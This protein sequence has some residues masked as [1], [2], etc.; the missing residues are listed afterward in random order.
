MS[1][2]III[3]GGGASGMLCAIK[4]ADKGSDVT[5]LERNERLG[6]K[7]LATG[8]GKCNLSNL[9]ATAD[10]Y[11][12]VFTK[13]ILQR[14]TPEKIKDEFASL[15][16]LCKSDNEGRI[17]PYSESATTVLNVLLQRL[18]ERGVK[19]VCDCFCNEIRKAGQGFNVITSKGEFYADAVVVATGSDATAGHNSH[20]L[21]SAFGHKI[22]SLN[23]AIAPLICKDI[24]GANGVRAKAYA[25]MEINGD[26]V[27]G[28][29]GELLFKDG[30]LSGIL[31]FRLS[32][33]LAR[34]G[35]KFDSCKV[36]IDFVPD[37]SENQLADYIYEN[38]SVFAPL[39]GILHKALAYNVIATIPM[40]RS[41]I[42]SR[43]KAADI[44]RACKNYKVDVLGVAGKNF[45]QVACGGIELDG[46][47]SSTMQSRL[48]KGIF[49][50]GEVVD[51]DGL[52]GGFNL[53]WAWASALA[54]SE[55][56]V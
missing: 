53:H 54:C 19:A 23:Y 12:D 31:A 42:M 41:L 39:E 47:D 38:C 14:F 3:I 46:I 27:M 9:G 22:K 10:A 44:A 21:L 25:R 43:K 2:K 37:L 51:V 49:A 24:K 32:S 35:G 13:D 52:C 28:E 17:Y 26:T 50:I 20:S 40:D 16:L 4:C 5:V 56:I 55:A 45:A 33:A 18:S 1:K 34:R 6:K 36:V 7:L 11:N 29:R 48:C 15:G 30:A 8:N